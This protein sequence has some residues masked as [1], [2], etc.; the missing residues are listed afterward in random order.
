MTTRSTNDLPMADEPAYVFDA[1][2]QQ[3]TARLAILAELFDPGTIRHLQARG[4]GAAWDCLEVGGGGGSIAAW[5]CDRVGPSGRVLTTDIDTRC[6]ETLRWPN[7]EVRRHDIVSDP[8]PTAAFNLVHVRLV[9]MHLPARE[10][11]IERLV[12]ALKPGG[13]LV[14][15]EFDVLSLRPDPAV[16]PLEA[17]L[18]T[19]LAL[20]QIMAER[21][22]HLRYGRLL[23]GRLR[24]HGLTDVDAEG[25][26]FVWQGSSAGARLAKT[27][28]EQLRR[29]M[30]ESGLVTDQEIEQDL[31]RLDDPSFTM[32]SPILWAAWGQR[33]AS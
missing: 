17:E 30:I 14:A 2:P 3:A 22:V 21:G 11:V 19:S 27:S 15:E 13:W 4:V 12:A 8:L 23:P 31:A 5:L 6:L 16:N 32:P 18:K 1:A 25:R 9:L 7:L 20:L 24:I 33:P 26:A 28:Y 29:V 10:R